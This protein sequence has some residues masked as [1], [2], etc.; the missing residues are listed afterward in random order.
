MH[1]YAIYFL[2]ISMATTSYDVNVTPDKRHIMFHNEVLSLL[3][4]LVQKYKY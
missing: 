2:N 3:A 4:L 1:Q